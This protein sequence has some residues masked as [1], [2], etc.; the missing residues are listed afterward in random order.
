MRVYLRLCRV[1]P[2]PVTV[3][4]RTACRS[5][6]SPVRPCSMRL[7]L[8]FANLP[9]YRRIYAVSEFDAAGCHPFA[10]PTA[11]SQPDSRSR[12]VFWSMLG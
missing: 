1:R 8:I 11:L 12:R 3:L 5:V 10:L 9:I 6:L 7:S 2:P 4:R